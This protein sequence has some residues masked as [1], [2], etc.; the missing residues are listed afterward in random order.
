[1]RRH[2]L[3]ACLAT[4][5][6]ALS[7]GS[8]TAA[9]RIVPTPGEL[10]RNPQA[11]FLVD[12]GDIGRGLETFLA[13]IN[14]LLGFAP[15]NADP[16]AEASPLC[17]SLRDDAWSDLSVEKRSQLLGDY[18]ESPKV[19]GSCLPCGR[20]GNRK[21]PI[22][23]DLRC[24][25]TGE[26]KRVRSIPGAVEDD[27][28]R[29]LEGFPGPETA[30]GLKQHIEFVY[31]VA[32]SPTSRYR[33]VL[34]PYAVRLAA[35]VAPGT[36]DPWA[37]VRDWLA[38]NKD[39]WERLRGLPGLLKQRRLE[40]VV[41]NWIREYDANLALVERDLA[42]LL[43]AP[44]GD[45]CTGNG[46]D[47]RKGTPTACEAAEANDADTALLRGDMRATAEA[48]TACT[49]TGD[50]DLTAAALWAAATAERSRL[51]T[52]LWTEAF[53]DTPKLTD[54]RLRAFD[55]GLARYIQRAEALVAAGRVRFNPQA[56]KNLRW[57]A[58]RLIELRVGGRAFIVPFV[59]GP[60]AGT[61]G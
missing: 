46:A 2:T 15:E 58:Q 40:W 33:E 19:P 52:A 45:G 44:A 34:K 11:P 39:L 16:E 59:R 12:T 7:A 32:N 8:A 38:T 53:I 47:C 5:V 31:D 50:G 1:M 18:R 29:F 57:A 54:A 22:L 27:R 21:A 25:I 55:A 30:W 36:A 10:L 35:V 4:A 9:Q 26:I 48:G 17:V 24:R 28:G 56:A 23:S 42:D 14:P 61:G 49:A 20:W 60:D 6:V 3:V 41:S 51:A 37:A 43:G 13:F